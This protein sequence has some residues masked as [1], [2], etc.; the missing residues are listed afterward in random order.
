[1]LCSAVRPARLLVAAL[2]AAASLLA[3]NA[4][5]AHAGL[6]V[7]TTTSCDNQPLSQPFLRWV[8][9]LTY[10]LAPNGGLEAGA[11]DWTLSKAS[12]V[13][14]NE[15]FYVHGSGDS[16]SLYLPAGSSATT[17]AMCVGLDHLAM[18]FF[19]KSKD[20]T[21]LS[22]SHLQVE[23]LFEDSG[24]NVR[25]LVIGSVLPSSKWAPT[26]PMLIVANLLPL[27]PG[28]S[29]P[30]AFRFTPKGK[31]SWWVDDIYVDPH[32]RS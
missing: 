30:V 6:L 31:G 21:L 24:G 16:K 14:G 25:S 17:R 8:D 18:R 2:L 20:T 28:S 29:T 27:L 23:V 1:M 26:L 10:T 4:A 13:T 32:R 12:V 9:P 19:A 22:L 15:S 3:L 5:P 7:K 11:T